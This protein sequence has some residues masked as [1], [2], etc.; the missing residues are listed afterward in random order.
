MTKEQPFTGH[1]EEITLDVRTSMLSIDRLLENLVVPD[2]DHLPDT[3]RTKVSKLLALAERDA[4]KMLKQITILR[5]GFEND[6]NANSNL[7]FLPHDQ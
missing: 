3:E 1:V 4:A 7:G 2:K 5:R 6:E